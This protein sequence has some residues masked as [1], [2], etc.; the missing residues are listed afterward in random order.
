MGLLEL[1]HADPH[2]MRYSDVL[3]TEAARRA[4]NEIVE[5]F[6]SPDVVR[7]MIESELHHDRPALA[8]VVKDL[9]ALIQKQIAEAMTVGDL[10]EGPTAMRRN[11][12]IGVIVRI[13]MKSNGWVPTGKKGSLAGLTRMFNR[14]ERYELKSEAAT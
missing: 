6:E 11:Q 7:R 9:E 13:V 2:A 14:G 3:H 5:F 12:M 4:L 1:F 10:G 8:G